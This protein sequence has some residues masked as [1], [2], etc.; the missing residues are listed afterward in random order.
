MF[1]IHILN[2]Q[3]VTFALINEAFSNV[4]YCSFPIRSYYLIIH[5][6]ARMAIKISQKYYFSR[7]ANIYQC[8]IQFFIKLIFSKSN[9]SFDVAYTRSTVI[10]I[11]R[12][13]M[14]T[15]IMFSLAASQFVIRFLTLSVLKWE[16]LLCAL[17]SSDTPLYR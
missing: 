10:L 14:L 8:F 11:P 6:C 13:F 3:I 12:S 7:C 9:L 2:S 17:L 16:L 5:F 4:I 15:V 1:E